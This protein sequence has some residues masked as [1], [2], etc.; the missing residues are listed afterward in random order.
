M[1]LLRTVDYKLRH[2][3]SIEDAPPYVALSHRWDPEG[4]VT[5][6]DIHHLDRA[7]LMSGWSKIQNACK[8]A[9]M[10]DILWIWID[11]CCIDKASS[12]ELSEAINSMFAL[13]LHSRICL[14]YL[15]DVPAG[16]KPSAP[17]SAF[18]S[19]GWFT[20]GWTLQ[21]L[22]APAAG[23][24]LFS[25]DWTVIGTRHDLR[26]VIEEITGIDRHMLTDVP[27]LFGWA[28]SK[29]WTARLRANSLAKRMSWAARRVT[30]RPEDRAY[31]L[32]GIFGVH[33]SIL[34]GEGGANAFRRLQ[35]QI[36]RQSADQT[37]FAWGHRLDS[38][39]VD[40]WMRTVGP[41]HLHACP[42]HSPLLAPSPDA[43]AHSGSIR[44]VVLKDFAAAAC[45]ASM[46]ASHY[47][48]THHGIH[49]RLPLRRLFPAGS[50]P[51]AADNLY[52][53]ALAC[54]D[55]SGTL[56]RGQRWLGLLLVQEPYDDAS[57]YRCTD[58]LFL[59]A[60]DGQ[61]PVVKGRVWSYPMW[62]SG[63]EVQT[64]YICT[65]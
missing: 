49:I 53:G 39:V 59:N 25:R 16:D 10:N 43:F 27:T 13:Y 30:T 31:S 46:K 22:L 63:W 50:S 34:Y 37:I 29:Q 62:Q 14:A 5:F 60:S 11:T 36:I 45:L 4:E 6:P 33:M 18:R 24:I 58:V 32:M 3:P 65:E 38:S 56:G 44:P 51:F 55:Q 12:A 17:K 61:F 41:R 35:L 23:M 28:D 47:Y 7:R 52:C 42:G 57:I 48:Q 8:I 21:E 40:G 15:G 1:W 64:I 26:S 20:R 2:F 9:A 54:S 19:S